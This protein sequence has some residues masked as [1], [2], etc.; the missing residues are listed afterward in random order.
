MTLCRLDCPQLVWEGK[1]WQ[2]LLYP[3]YMNYKQLDCFVKDEKVFCREMYSIL[4]YSIVCGDGLFANSCSRLSGPGKGD[5]LLWSFLLFFSIDFVFRSWP[6]CQI[7]FSTKRMNHLF[8]VTE[9]ISRKAWVRNQTMCRRR[10]S[11]SVAQPAIA[12]GLFGKLRVTVQPKSHLGLETVITDCL[13]EMCSKK[14][15]GKYTFHL[16]R[17]LLHLRCD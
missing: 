15:G 8:K 9:D 3:Y 17:F 12:E 2:F 14:R 4:L 1:N 16:L 7:L 11:T 6:C 10:K 13:T 5:G